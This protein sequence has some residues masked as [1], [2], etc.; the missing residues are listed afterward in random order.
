MKLVKTY[1]NS[2][3]STTNCQWHTADPT[4]RRHVCILW[5]E[6]GRSWWYSHVDLLVSVIPRVPGCAKCKG[7][8]QVQCHHQLPG[9]LFHPWFLL[10]CIPGHLA[11]RPLL[12]HQH[13]KYPQDQAWCAPLSVGHLAFRPLLLHPYPK[14]P[15]DQA[16]CAP[17]SSFIRAPGFQTPS[18]PS[19]PTIS[20]RPS[21]VQSA[22]SV[23][24]GAYQG[25]LCAHVTGTI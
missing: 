12:L 19:A 9:H 16:W 20:T 11:S 15:Q 13:P 21:M 10:L 23:S 22:T 2:A 17:D 5:W 3:F 1:L 6:M 25:P 14:S 4:S 18:S 24:K 8:V 7:S